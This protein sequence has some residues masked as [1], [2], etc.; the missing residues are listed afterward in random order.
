MEEIKRLQILKSEFNSLKEM[1]FEAFL[2]IKYVDAQL[3]RNENEFLA[4]RII[5]RNS[6]WYTISFIIGIII[7]AFIPSI[8]SD[9]VSPIWNKIIAIIILIGCIFGFIYNMLHCSFKEYLKILDD[10]E[11]YEKVNRLF[12]EKYNK[13]D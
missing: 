1:S 8:P 10:T 9:Y 2:N 5:K 7:A 12:Q 4:K 13:E 3:E 11:E 6:I